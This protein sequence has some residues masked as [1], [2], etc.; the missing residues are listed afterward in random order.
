MR[1]VPPTA[2]YCTGVGHSI[3]SLLLSILQWIT[4][5][6]Q[7]IIQA[8]MYKLKLYACVFLTYVT[9]VSLYHI[10]LT[11]VSVATLKGDI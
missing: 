7:W 3:R 1:D 8:L 4:V 5:D 10:Y 11:L 9:Q 2:N 6:N